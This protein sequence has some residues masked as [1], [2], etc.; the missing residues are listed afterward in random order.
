MTEHE[1]RRYAAVILEVGVALRPG[2]DLAVNAHL[3]HKDFARLLCD[4]AY[5]RGAALV[6][7]WYWDPHTKRARLEHAPIETL[8]RTP[9]WLDDRYHRLARRGGALVNLSGD[10]QP[11]RLRDIEP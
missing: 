7:L 3:A 9:E 6:D 4:E 5:R 10:P 1:L 8:S 11:D 2:Q